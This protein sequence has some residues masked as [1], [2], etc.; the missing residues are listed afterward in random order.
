MTATITPARWVQA[1]RSEYLES[2]VPEGGAAIKFCV[3]LDEPARGTTW[4]ALSEVGRELGYVVVKIDASET[5]VNLVDRLFFSTAAQIDWPG[6]AERVLNRLCERAGYQ[7]PESSEMS[8]CERVA[9]RNRIAAEIVNINLQQALTEEV[10][11]GRDLAK[12]FRVA[13]TRLCL[14][15]LRGGA[16]AP[17]TVR[18]LTDWLTGRN[19]NVSAV[20]Q[21]QIFNR[22]TRTNA[23]RLLE[24]LIRWVRLA[25][26]PGTLVL[27]DI[28]RLAVSRNP[29]DDRPFYNNAVLLDALEVLREFVDSTD[30][31]T[32]CLIAVL[33]DAAFLD[34]TSGRGI[35]SY[36]ALELRIKDD[37][38]AKEVVNPMAAL[39]RL[40][41]NTPEAY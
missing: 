24:S 34:E 22:V 32:H 41:T 30:R 21:Y 12:D 8:F 26:F 27:L 36:Q 2:F 5:K 19:P 9:E 25:G 14:A 13:M 37:V 39:V 18:A 40:S 11:R 10:F 7:L 28:A 16:D 29:R 23:R 15:R 20:K 17:I 6:S 3:P 1:I 33:P 31:L 38:R 4:N 35:A